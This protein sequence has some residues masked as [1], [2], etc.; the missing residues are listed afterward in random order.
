MIDLQRIEDLKMIRKACRMESGPKRLFPEVWTREI[1][2][3]ADDL[4]RLAE[5]AL[6]MKEDAEK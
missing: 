4:L 3:D 5:A 2:R 6:L 1:M